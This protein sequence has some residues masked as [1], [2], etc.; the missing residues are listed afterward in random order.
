MGQLMDRVAVITGASTGIGRSIA[1][2]FASEGAKVV[3]ASRSRQKLEAVAG[4][5]QAAGGTALVVPMDVTIEE[6]VVDLR[7]DRYTREQCRHLHQD[8]NRPIES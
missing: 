6:N 7:P 3:L 4:E 8:T 5:I 2:A 1:S